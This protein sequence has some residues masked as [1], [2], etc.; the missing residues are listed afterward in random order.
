MNYKK[1]QSL[2]ELLIAMSVFVLAV[3]VITFLILDAYLADRAGRERMK[4]TFLAREGIEATRSI[5]DNNWDSL[6]NG[7]Y[8]LAISENNWIFQGSGED[9]SNQLREGLRKIIVEEIDSDRKK[10]TSQVT[11]RF[12]ET[13]TQNVSL[14]TYLTYWA[15]P[16]PPFITQLH[17]RWRNDD[18]GN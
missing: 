1:G 3:S 15:K 2:I 18:G 4:A 16:L 13:R 14:I 12:T 6:T 8:G 10:I 11:W 5:R 9:I 17:Y 7:S